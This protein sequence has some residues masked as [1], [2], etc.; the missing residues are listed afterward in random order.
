MPHDAFISYSHG[1]DRELA[2]AVEAGLEKLGKPLLKLRGVLDVFRDET[3]LAASPELWTGILKHLAEAKWFLLMACPESASSH[4]CNR[5]IEW[6]VENRG[7]ERMLILLT[8][9][10]IVWSQSA[11][12]FDQRASTAISPNLRGKLKGEPFYVD[13]RW[14]RNVRNLTLK[15]PRFR[16]A[17]LNISSPLRGVPKDELDSDDVRQ[18]Q[19]NRR[20]VWFGATGLATA[21]VLA[22]G[23]GFLAQ[24]QERIAVSRSLAARSAGVF[25]THIDQ[26]LTLAV[27]AAKASDTSEA[28][29]AVTR[30]LEFL[31]PARSLVVY[32]GATALAVGDLSKGFLAGT[33]QGEILLWNAQPLEPVAKLPACHEG[34][35]TKIVL[36]RSGDIAV[37]GDDGGVLCIWEMKGKRLLRKWVAEKARVIVG[38]DISNDERTIG[39]AVKLR[40]AGDHDR[41]NSLVL[42]HLPAK[43]DLGNLDIAKR[44]TLVFTGDFSISSVAFA[45][46]QD[47]LLL[48]TAFGQLAEVADWRAF[49]NKSND[50][51]LGERD[52]MVLI[53]NHGTPLT[54]LECQPTG[55]YCATG[56][57]DD[58]LVAVVDVTRGQDQ[59]EG[60]ITVT[61]GRYRSPVAAIRYS[62]ASDRLVIATTDGEAQVYAVQDLQ[63]PLAAIPPKRPGWVR[64]GAVDATSSNALVSSSDGILAVWNLAGKPPDYDKVGA[65]SQLVRQACALVQ[66]TISTELWSAL[67]GKSPYPRR[68]EEIP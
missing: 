64:L 8:G 29:G 10:D 22:A 32:S 34:R 24:R 56:T 45:G 59:F 20:F 11:R 33:A 37:S 12:D 51:V 31:W 7:T 15:D 57:H 21:V 9:G 35:V 50:A 53:A 39:I 38:M 41:D 3:S 68:C 54:H 60:P 4:W 17:I 19:R 67:M 52:R 55:R 44:T 47:R 13:L 14:A 36:A 62:H 26:A 66:A 30:V 63:T 28:R 25:G 5:E 23:L 48:G 27:Q 61:R 58:G 1:A 16:S 6:W 42:W 2:P 18:L 65:T 43:G 40:G 49:V 46:A